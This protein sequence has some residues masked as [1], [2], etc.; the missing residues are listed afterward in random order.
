MAPATPLCGRTASPS[1]PL[2]CAILLSG[3]GSGMEAL[4]Q[5]QRGQRLPHTTTVVLSNRPDAYGL[6]RA[7]RLSVPCAV[8]RQEDGSGQR[9]S[10]EQHEERLLEEL[11]AHDV[12]LIVLAGYMRLL[13]PVMLE[14]WGGRIVNIHPSL[15]PHFP[16]A[17]AHRDVLAAGATISGC[18]VHMV[19]EGMDTGAVLA[20]ACV[21]VFPNDTEASL[22][23]RV[24]VEEHRLYP[25]VLTWIAEGRVVLTP[26]GAQVDGE[27]PH[28]VC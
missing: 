16:G 18:T 20:Q 8:V 11:E 28:R 15:L 2:R 19:D 14:R 27:P 23:E 9:L 24:K 26:N 17:H 25:Q 3:S 21:P 7:R 13:S 5:T 6:E 12:E 4:V 1:A 22:S 10:R